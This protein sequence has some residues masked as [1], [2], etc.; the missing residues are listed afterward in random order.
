MTTL[1]ILHKPKDVFISTQAE[2]DH[3]KALITNGS[4]W[5]LRV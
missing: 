3:T 2:S 4:Q 1:R 5:P